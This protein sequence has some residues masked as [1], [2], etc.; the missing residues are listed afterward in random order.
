M[1]N[2]CDDGNPIVIRMKIFIS[3]TQKF[4]MTFQASKIK[5]I[6]LCRIRNGFAKNSGV[7]PHPNNPLE[8]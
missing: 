4:S 2:V 6:L 3:Q 7:Y 8:N 5:D 1:T